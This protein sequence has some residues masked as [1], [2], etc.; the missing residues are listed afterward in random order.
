MTPEQVRIAT[1]GA[2]TTIGQQN[3]G[4]VPEETLDKTD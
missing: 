4:F 2:E 1:Q 3:G